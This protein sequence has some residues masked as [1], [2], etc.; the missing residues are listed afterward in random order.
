MLPRLP[1]SAA[2]VAAA[3]ALAACGG[4][5]EDS[6]V[7]AAAPPASDFPS[8][9]GRTL[10]QL[11]A[12][13]TAE[14]PVV[15][16]GSTT[17]RPGE[18]RLTFGVFDPGGEPIPDAQVA[19]YVAK[20]AKGEAQGPFPAAVESLVP[21]AAFTSRTTSQDP[22][23]P[24]TFYVSDVEFPANGEFRVLAMVREG[25]GYSASLMQSALVGKWGEIPEPGDKA[26]VVHTPT[27]EDVAD[28]SEI[29]TRD[30]HDSMHEEDLA[31]VLGEKPVVL[32]M[33]TPALCRSRVC[34]PSVDIAEQ[35]K[36]EHGD[37]A[38]FIHMEIYEENSV[39]K[40]LRPQVEAYGLQT[41]PWIFVIGA[42]GV[43]HS[44]FE[45][46]IS[47]TELETAVEEVGASS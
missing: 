11:A 3:L 29:D 13:A 22:D 10:E 44:E 6:S 20:G 38:A 24:P 33:A 19:L 46:P 23:V 36:S 2:V 4:D 45:G 12:E 27:E 35:V 39:D 31:D 37:D 26:P 42:D 40:G 9:D 16:P 30:P 7:A 28:L 5:E 34:G 47:V 8:P 41:E 32:V 43:V 25:S 21:D 15:S 14:G 18:N 17:F 1:M